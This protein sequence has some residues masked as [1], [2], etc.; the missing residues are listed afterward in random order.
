MHN[1][2]ARLSAV[3]YDLREVQRVA[4]KPWLLWASVSQRLLAPLRVPPFTFMRAGFELFERVWK[5]YEKPPFAL[6][7]TVLRLPDGSEAEVAVTERIA[8]AK[9]FCNLIHFERDLPADR[10]RDPTVLV[11]APLSGHHATLLRDTVR[12]LLPDHDVWITDWVDAR[13]VPLIE[14]A[15][16]LDDYVQYAVDF[17]R[18]LGP[19]VHVLAVCQP[20]VPVLAAV[21][22]MSA[23]DDAAVPRSLTLMGGPIDPRKSPTKVNEL[24]VTRDLSWFEDNLVHA[25][26][27]GRPGAGRRVYPGFLQLTAFVSMNVDRHAE[28]HTKFFFDVATG[29]ASSASSHRA[30]YDE[31]NAVLDMAAEYYL[32]TVRVVFQQHL[33]PRGLW[34]VRVDGAVRRVDPTAV[35]GTALLTVEGELDDISGLGQTEAAH[36]LCS[37][38][39]AERRRHHVEPGAGHY[40]IFSG[41]RFRESILPI[42]RDFVRSA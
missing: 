18:A 28:S 38:I 30:F 36:G 39:P 29:D 35:R 40:G 13:L 10:P 31:Y 19:D 21:S 20:T 8:I 7:T 9:P 27:F 42:V 17:I 34:D 1:E 23:L 2:A 32:D 26:P 24:A 15:F 11:F 4:L 41:R 3:L 6:P 25:V 5:T 22:V 14:G 37:A 12:G 33:L 16:S